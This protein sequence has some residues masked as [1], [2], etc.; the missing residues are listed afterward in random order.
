V[1][2][3]RYFSVAWLRN[4]DYWRDSPGCRSMQ[5]NYDLIQLGLRIEL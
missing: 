5:L 1:V 4:E 3:K 2:D